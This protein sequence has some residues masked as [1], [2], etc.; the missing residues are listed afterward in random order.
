MESKKTTLTRIYNYDLNL[1]QQQN[2]NTSS[3]NAIR[4]LIWGNK[5]KWFV[6]GLGQDLTDLVCLITL[7]PF[8][9]VLIGADYLFC[10]EPSTE[11]SYDEE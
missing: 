9:A 5:K 11:S 4:N 10:G 1:L 7:L 8:C 3:A 6:M 2:K